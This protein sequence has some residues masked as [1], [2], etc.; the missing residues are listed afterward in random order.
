MILVCFLKSRADIIFLPW[1]WLLAL[2]MSWLL[3]NFSQISLVCEFH[4]GAVYFLFYLSWKMKTAL[5]L[6]CLCISQQSVWKLFSSYFTW[7][8]YL[9]QSLSQVG[10][11]RENSIFFIPTLEG[12]TAIFSLPCKDDDLPVKPKKEW[13]HM[14]NV[15]FEK[16]EWMKDLP[17]PR[18]K[19]TKKVWTQK[20]VFFMFVSG[21]CLSA[22]AVLKASKTSPLA[23][24][25]RRFHHA[26][27]FP[28]FFH[29]VG[30]YMVSSV[31]S[32][33]QLGSESLAIVVWDETGLKT[34]KKGKRGVNFF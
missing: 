32:A 15:E 22:V 29:R 9:M 26:E 33:W 16:L 17:S 25:F 8:L 2:F 3:F 19:K 6:W 28:S 1:F 5:N 31:C 7:I 4:C 21:S 27:R 12:K 23:T 14:D 10:W 30:W 34:K 18:Q 11:Q 13:I 20:L 24:Q